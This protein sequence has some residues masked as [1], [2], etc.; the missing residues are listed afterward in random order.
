M[1]KTKLF[2]SSTLPYVNF[3]DS[4]I[5][6]ENGV[7]KISP[8][9]IGHCY[10]FVL[11]DV[12][13]RYY[14]IKLGPQ[15]VFF[16]TGIDEHGQKVFES[17][18]SLNLPPQEYCDK[19]SERWKE[20]C[21]KFNISYDNFY[22]TSDPDHKLKALT[23]FKQLQDSDDIFLK[24]YTGLYCKG[25]EAFKLEKDLINEKCDQHPTIT[26]ETISEENY[27]FK[28]SKY[29]DKI[30]SN[31]LLDNTLQKS[32]DNI[33]EDSQDMSVSRN[34]EKVSW[35]IEI[36]NTNQTIYC[37]Q[38]ALANYFFAAG[39]IP[40]NEISKEFLSW[41]NNSM[42]VCGRDNLRFQA[43][44]LPGLLAAIGLSAPSKVFVH[45]IIQDENG[46]KMSKS[47]GNVIDPIDQLEKY[48]LNPLRYYL[49]AGLN[50]FGNSSYSE[51]ELVLKYNNDIVNGYGNLLSRTL[52]LIDIKS[53][54]IDPSLI[55]EKKHID[56]IIDS[57]STEFENGDLRQ[58]Y[59][60]IL[61]GVIWAN[62]IITEER[63]FSADCI[64]PA[65]ILNN[66][67]YLLT[68]VSPFYNILFPDLADS[69]ENALR[70]KKKV[71][72]FKRLEDVG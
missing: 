4:L 37:W 27:F 31:I 65:E 70:E 68:Q 11:T 56:D 42:I 54:I 61:R 47:T 22:R 62:K 46:S 72:L 33:I 67:Y 58:A 66:V 25:C 14:R 38:E 50:S 44:I 10:E 8:G 19:L 1:F 69:I 23:F 45:G 48:G 30:P 24:K 64:N 53:I 35:A 57:A 5:P 60:Y 32:L 16:N 41:W 34:K 49:V 7:L 13:A 9:H 63:P 2:I 20:F 26:I 71:I 18:Q 59:N 55:T 21:E 6:D 17:A 43:V 39:Y 40:G 28:L 12:I 36:P 15:N 29:V 51:K 3:P 52:H